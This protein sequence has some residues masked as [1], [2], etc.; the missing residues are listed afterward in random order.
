M[1]GAGT[2][3]SFRANVSALAGIRLETRLVH[4]VHFPRTETEIL[5]LRLSLPLIVAPIGGISF[6][7]GGAMGE[8]EYQEAI[9]FGAADAGIVA[10]TPDAV[11]PE[12]MRAGLAMA[13]RLG[14][15]RAVPFV[16]PWEPEKIREKLEMARGAGCRVVGCDL[17]SIGLVTLRIMGNPAY[18]K[19]QDD[20]AGIID[21]AHGLGLSFVVKGIMGPGDA[22]SCV[23]AGADG[24]VVSNHGGRVLDSVPGTAEVLP[25]IAEKIKGRAA[26]L[27]DGGFRSGADILKALALGADGVMIG[28]PFAIAA[29][30]GGREGVALYA[31]TLRAQLEQ[32]MIMTGCPDVREA[33][34][35]L[36][37]R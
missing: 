28:R 20:L 29:V 12:V 17:D 7:L 34:P 24:L 8:A 14:E 9:V 35:G 6:N 33:G 15:G 36:L 4:Q 37:R 13:E 32:A 30:G 26:I 16:K 11:P 10:G 25:A 23:G 21:S 19:S 22:V 31:E 5:G 18:A 2:G 27:V 3:L 1:G